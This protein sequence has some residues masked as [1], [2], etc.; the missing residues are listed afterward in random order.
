MSE[1]TLFTGQPVMNQLLSLIPKWLVT[2]LAEK[3]GADRYCK[4]FFSQDHLVTMLYSTFSQCG[5]LRELISGLQV[6]QHRLLHLGLLSTP[7]R[8]TLADANARRPEAFFEELLHRL[9]QLHMGGLPDSRLGRRDIWSRLFIMD[10]TTISLFTDTMQGVGRHPHNGRRKGGAKAHVLMRAQEDVACFVRIAQGKEN[11]KVMF[12]H[13]VLPQGSIVALDKGFNSYVQYALWTEQGVLF[14]TRM[15]ENAVYSVLEERDVSENQRKLGVQ[16]DRV[17]EMTGA[18]NSGTTRIKAR[19]V[20]FYDAT[21][22][23]LFTFMTNDMVHA[24]ATIAAIYK[25]RWQIELLFKRIKHNYP[26]HYFLGD[27]PNAIKI[28]IWCA[29]IADLLLKVVKDRVERSSQRRWSFANLAGIVRLHLTTY[30]DLFAFLRNP[31]KALL[32]YRPPDL[33][34]QQLAFAFA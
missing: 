10:S 31:E 15:N 30:V 20:H 1:S 16:A 18:G 34:T 27:S 32:R 23:R 8:S 7:C 9:Y 26:L 33:Q 13:A 24:P 28:Q 25:R 22:Q 29:L 11:D 19:L 6:N 12:R 5:S 17:V 4:N 14:V 2:E 3:H 21:T